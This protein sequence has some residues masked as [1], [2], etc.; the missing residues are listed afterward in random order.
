ME[1]YLD[2][3]EIL[4]IAE[5]AKA[6]AIHPGYGFLS[7]DAEFAAACRNRRIAFIGPRDKV[8]RF[9]GDKVQARAH[10]Q[11]LGIPMVPGLDLEVGSEAALNNAEE[12]FRSMERFW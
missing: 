10:A 6:D 8:I 4:G 2:V 5:Q 12:L 9:L 11:E 3:D 7:E 1:A